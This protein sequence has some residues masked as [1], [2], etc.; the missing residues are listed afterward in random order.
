MKAALAVARNTFREAV[1]DRVLFLVVG[2]GAVLIAASRILSPIALGEGP[3]ITVD[4]GLA[5]LGLVGFAIVALIGTNLVYKEIERRTVHVVLSRPLSRPAYLVGKWMGLTA[6]MA[7]A[8]LAMGTV[9]AV[10]AVLLEG[11]RILVPWCRPCSSSSAP[12]ACSPPSP[13]CSRRFR[14]RCSPPSTR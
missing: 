3:R 1:R 12:T 13:C 7:A 4:L 5:G 14:R 2:F 8:V 11:P 10:M 6:T 9:L